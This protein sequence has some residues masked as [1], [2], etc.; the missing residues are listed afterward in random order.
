M[1]QG[2]E[3]D[4]VERYLD[5]L[6]RAGAGVGLDWQGLRETVESRFDSVA[7]RRRDEAG[8]LLD[9]TPD[10]AVRIVFDERGK[11]ISSEDFAGLVGRYRDDGRDLVCFIGGPDG[12]DPAF[13]DA[14]DHVLSFG[15]MT[16]PH[17][18]ARLI[19][20]EQLYRAATILAGHPY[21]RS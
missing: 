2:P 12:H 17:Q 16:F 11:T 18:L 15:K 13:T 6:K 1:K 19:L 5:R 14:A 8:R 3:R 21:H 9:G 7:A 20:A 4:L 10:G